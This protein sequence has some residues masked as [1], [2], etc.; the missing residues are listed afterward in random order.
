MRRKANYQSGVYRY[1]QSL[2]ILNESLEVIE[3]AK[4]KYWNAKK[5]Q[6][7][8]DKA[9]KEKSFTVSFTQIELREIAEASAM[10]NMS[11]SRFIKQ[12]CLAYVDKKYL[13]PNTESLQNIKALLARNY[14]IL[15][16]VY[17]GEKAQPE[18]ATE[19]LLRM[20]ILER[21]VLSELLHPKL[22]S[23]DR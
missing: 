5:L 10:H 22:L 11:R 12:A 6:S 8:K 2:G 13:V 7:K 19:L 4:K 17:E 20:E 23:N 14:S 21:L 15:Q 18:V 3:H 16:E 9:K 1:L